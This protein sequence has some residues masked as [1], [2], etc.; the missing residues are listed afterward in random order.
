MFWLIFVLALAVIGGIGYVLI[1]RSRGGGVGYRDL[2]RLANIRGWHFSRPD[3]TRQAFGLSAE[4][5]LKA[6]DGSSM[7][8]RVR[9]HLRA[10]REDG[11]DKTEIACGDVLLDS[12]WVFVNPRTE[13]SGIKAMQRAAAMD[14]EDPVKRIASWKEQ[15]S[16]ARDVPVGTPEF[17]DRYF[18]SATIT[19]AAARRIVSQ[20]VQKALLALPSLPIKLRVGAD[21]VVVSTVAVFDQPRVEKLIALEDMLISNVGQEQTVGAG[22]LVTA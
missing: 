9:W 17:L 11:K 3:G 6:A 20:R 5:M 18:V 21:G 7:D 14:H 19:E 15:L 1:S 4:T 2:Q 10:T 16:R 12:G 8:W 13:M 22:V